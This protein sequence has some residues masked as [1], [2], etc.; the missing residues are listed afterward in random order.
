MWNILWRYCQGLIKYQVSS[1]H[2]YRVQTRFGGK[3]IYSEA[4]VILFTAEG[5]ESGGGWPG[6]S[7]LQSEKRAVRILL[8]CFLVTARKRSL[9][10]G[11]IFAPICLS[12]HRGGSTW[13][14]TPPL[15]QLHPLASTPRP[16]PGRYAPWQVHPPPVHAGIWSTSGRYASYWNAFLFYII[17][18]SS[19]C[20]PMF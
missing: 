12:V 17:F 20:Q 16:P 5:S 19:R 18:A 13:A 14:G 10:Q 1:W 6:R 15:R 2:F 11:N 8:E 7:H 3:V 4:S 9:G